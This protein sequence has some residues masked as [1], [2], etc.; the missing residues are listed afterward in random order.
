MQEELTSIVKKFPP[1]FYV[2]R[3][4][5]RR[6]YPLFH[7]KKMF[8]DPASIK[9]AWYDYIKN[10]QIVRS[11][12]I[13]ADRKA[14]I[15]EFFGISDVKLLLYYLRYGFPNTLRFKQNLSKFFDG[16]T[17]NDRHLKDAYEDAAF[18]YTLRLMLAYTRHNQILPYLDFLVKKSDK[19]LTKFH[20]L[21]YGC[22][23]SDVGI[24]LGSLGAKVTIADL[25]DKKFSFAEWRFKRRGISVDTVSIK[26]SSVYPNLG[27]DKYDLILVTE[28]FEHVRDPLT[29]LRRL[30]TALHRGGFLLDSMAGEFERETGGDHLEEAFEIGNSNEY[31]HYYTDHYNH[32]VLDG[33][34]KCL[35]QKK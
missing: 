21:D 34:F 8:F 2:T 14:E 27:E 30:T 5:Y 16:K 15:K 13:F 33:K 7:A 4:V 19:P 6:F 26:D 17:N 11:R 18:H 3:F 35:F 31:K 1:V 12:P 20:V 32:L 9:T 22:G 29:L 25:A 10:T 28:V 23:V 24:L